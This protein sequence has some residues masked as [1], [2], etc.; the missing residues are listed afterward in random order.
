[1]TMD[2]ELRLDGNAVAGLL[3]EVFSVEATTA[4]GRCRS[5]GAEGALA[6]AMVYMHA[7][8]VVMRC[9]SCTAV[10]MRFAHIRGRLMADLHGVDR[11][12]L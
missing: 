4:V 12:M 7:P 3:T 2:S 9:P 1:M 6:E 10:L 8:G 11:F 5:C